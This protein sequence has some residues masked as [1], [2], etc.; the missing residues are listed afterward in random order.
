LL[1]LKGED[2]EL[3][4]ALGEAQ[5]A[6]AGGIVT[7]EARSSIDQAQ[8]DS[9]GLPMA[10]FYLGLAA[11]QDGESKKAIEIY[12]SLL[13]ETNDQPH[14]QRIV[15]ARL[16]ALKGGPPAEAFAAPATE[17]TQSAA[18]QSSA[19]ESGTG[20]EDMIRGMVARLASRLAE[21]GGS[22]EDWTRL[23]RSYA[24]LREEDKA[25]DALASARKAL[26]A[27]ANASATL[28][29]LAKQLGLGNP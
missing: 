6:A 29:A 17:A 20:Q 18:S 27:D 1:R 15:K 2:G 3:R 24:V 23:V 21:S 7:D 16:A 10:R 4:A 12:Q 8:A 11:E 9:P 14:W 25:R 19:S 28:E 13:D 26:A 5:V 22:A